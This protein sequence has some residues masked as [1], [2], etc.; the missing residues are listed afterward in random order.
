[1]E[2]APRLLK[3]L[4]IG[5][6]RRLDASSTKLPK[7]WDKIQKPVVPLERNFCGHPLA[8]LLW[9]RQLEEALFEFGWEKVPNW[10]CTFV[11]REQG[12]FL[13]ENVDD[14]KMAG[15]K[16]NIVP[17]WKMDEKWGS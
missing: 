15:K 1:M 14:I 10:E 2:D 4:Q 5:M 3:S 9:E 8:G 11:H 16:Q 6:S 17:M 7:S 13:S 12:L